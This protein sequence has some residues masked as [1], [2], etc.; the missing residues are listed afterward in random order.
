M[1][2]LPLKK[3]KNEHAELVGKIIAGIEISL[4]NLKFAN[5]EK[6]FF[7][8]LHFGI[9]YLTYVIY[10]RFDE[11]LA[12]EIKDLC[13]NFALV[14]YKDKTVPV[15]DCIAYDKE[16]AYVANEL[17][18]DRVELAKM[19]NINYGTLLCISHSFRANEL[20]R[21]LP[22]ALGSSTNIGNP[23]LASLL[24]KYVYNN[25]STNFVE[26][27]HAYFQIIDKILSIM[28]EENWI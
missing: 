24:C 14:L 1:P 21:H 13:L 16:L 15:F 8:M 26:I 11:T 20:W 6:V 25:E 19:S 5:H 9:C 2:P 23:L 17:N 4:K 27:Q 3:I 28:K 7:T 22:D 18:L 10:A 12:E